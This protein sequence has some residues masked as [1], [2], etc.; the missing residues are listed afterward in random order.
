MLELSVQEGIDRVI[1]YSNQGL[2]GHL[3]V[4]EKSRTAVHPAAIGLAGSSSKKKC[5]IKCRGVSI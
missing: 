1:T 2:T 3:D 4:L 5:Q